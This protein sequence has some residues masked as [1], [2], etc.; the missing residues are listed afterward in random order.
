MT[1]KQD[2]EYTT[3]SYGMLL[4]ATGSLKGLLI[5]FRPSAILPKVGQDL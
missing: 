2:G 1:E 3:L 4:N 5:C